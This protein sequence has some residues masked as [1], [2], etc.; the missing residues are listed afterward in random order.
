MKI[1][2][3]AIALLAALA[4]MQAMAYID[5]G[6]GSAIMSAIIGFFVAIAMVVK[7]Y[8]YKIKSLFTGSKPA[9]ADLTQ[10]DSVDASQTNS[11][12]SA[13]PAAST[14]DKEGRAE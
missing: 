13:E 6:S 7:T 3:T 8:W 5:P 12:T 10:Q 1:L 11:A 9:T 14:A 4:P 2:V